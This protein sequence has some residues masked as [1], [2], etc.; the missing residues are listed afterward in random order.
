MNWRVPVLAGL[1]VIAG[2]AGSSV[3]T[4]LAQGFPAPGD[5]ARLYEGAKR[6]GTVVWYGGAPLEP[7]R[8]MADDFERQYPGV[9]V[10]ILR[11][12]GIPQYQRFMQESE[13]KQ[14]I[15][16][17]L[18]L[19]DSP[20]MIDLVN[21]HYVAEWKVPT[22][23]RVPPDARIGTN[24]YAAWVNDVNIAYN[25]NKVSAEEVAMLA[26]D[27]RNLLDPRFKGRLAT[28]NQAACGFCY[29]QIQMF[30]SPQYKDRFGWDFLKALA[31]QKPALYGDAVVA[32]DRVIAG[33][34]DIDIVGAEG[35]VVSKWAAGAPIRWVHPSPTPAYG[36]TWFGVSQFAPHPYAARLLINWFM[37][38]DGAKSIQARY[39]GINMLMGYA[40]QRPVTR[41]PWY[42]P[43]K[44]RYTPDWN[45]W[46]ANYEGDW[47]AWTKLLKESQ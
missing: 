30:L 16:D 13:A 2:L 15:V 9:K 42:S 11:I 28:M 44:D 18:H 10:E 4:A 12:P 22:F 37:S 3:S 32:A 47:A 25:P 29:A 1:A 40:D 20:S 26:A 39:G 33:E 41:E 23:D 43:I 8:A 38:V 46:N 31:A 45:A 19:G 24:A 35:I 5:E 17:L 6:E 21:R 7:M 27:W 34:Q 14:Y 36:N